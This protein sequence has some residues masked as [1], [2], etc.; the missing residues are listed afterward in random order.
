MLMEG[1]TEAGERTSADVNADAL[2][3]AVAKGLYPGAFD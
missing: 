3:R 1:V 2:R